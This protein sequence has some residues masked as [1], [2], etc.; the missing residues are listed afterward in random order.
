VP[1]AALGHDG[2]RHR[3]HDTHDHVR[4]AHARHAALRT[5]VRRDTLQRHNGARARL[6]RDLGLLRRDH[7]H[8]DAALEHLRQTAFDDD[9]SYIF[10]HVTLHFSGKFS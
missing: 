8:D 7:I 4:I 9:C 10:L 2:N 1:N 5:N 3:L 6:F